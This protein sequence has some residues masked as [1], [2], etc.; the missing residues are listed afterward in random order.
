MGLIDLKVI[1]ISEEDKAVTSQII[2]DTFT[3]IKADI[4][5]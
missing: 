2:E 3:L 1:S 5:S 4:S